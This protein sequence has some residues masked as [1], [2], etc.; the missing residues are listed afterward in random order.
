MDTYHWKYQLWNS[1]SMYLLTADT[2]QQIHRSWIRRWVLI[3]KVWQ[4]LIILISTSVHIYQ[5]PN[6]EVEFDVGIF[7]D[8]WLWSTII[9]SIGPKSTF[10]LAQRGSAL[11]EQVYPYPDKNI[12]MV[13]N[14]FKKTLTLT[15]HWWSWRPMVARASC[16]PRSRICRCGSPRRCWGWAGHW[17]KCRF[18]LGKSSLARVSENDRSVN[19]EN[20]NILHQMTQ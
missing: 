10:N 12:I 8:K 2:A 4:G 18:L 1:T 11:G 14:S 16:C 13:N 15:W 9:L 5:K 6:I 7:S 17:N 19:Y 3:C 20:R